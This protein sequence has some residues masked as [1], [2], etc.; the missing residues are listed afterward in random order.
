V[1][2]QLVD[3]T[4]L[5]RL[6]DDVAT[7]H[8]H[9]G[10]MRRRG[11]SLVDRCGQTV[12]ESEAHPQLSLDADILRRRVGDDEER[13]RPRRVDRVLFGHPGVQFGS[14]AESV[15]SSA[16]RPVTYPSNVIVISA[17]TFGIAVSARRRSPVQTACPS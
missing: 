2:A 1:D 4:L 10:A 11:P 3:E 8:D 6:A 13:R 9:D 7:A 5:E 17:M 15:L 16:P 14:V 12:D